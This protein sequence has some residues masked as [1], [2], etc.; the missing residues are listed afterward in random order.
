MFTILNFILFQQ[1]Y[2]FILDLIIIQVFSDE[3]Y[4]E[5]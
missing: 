3:I 1:I 2:Y 4:V 5:I